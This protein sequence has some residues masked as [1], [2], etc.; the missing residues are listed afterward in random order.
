MPW[1][2]VLRAA[3]ATGGNRNDHQRVRRLLVDDGHRRGGR[4][5]GADVGGGHAGR[6]EHQVPG[7]GTATPFTSSM[8]I[9]LCG[10]IM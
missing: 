6:V 5:A 9:T 8:V 3:V 1:V 4:A 7:N 2:P 10:D